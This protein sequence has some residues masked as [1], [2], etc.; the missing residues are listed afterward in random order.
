[1]KITR[2]M[3]SQPVKQ[4]NQ[5]K[6]VDSSFKQ[7]VQSQTASIEKEEL[8]HLMNKISE[9]GEKLAR[10][11]SFRD[12]VRFKH[13]I[14]NFLE[15]TVYDSYELRSSFSF[16]PHGNSKQLKTVQEIDEKLVELTEMIMQQEEK[17]V[18]LLDVIGEIKGL[19]VNLYT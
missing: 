13:L 9:Q 16:H 5:Q 14:K 11:R 1:M 18:N 2:E 12:L 7:M 10:F 17:S 3:S 4:L 19:L 8:T 6:Q 15:K